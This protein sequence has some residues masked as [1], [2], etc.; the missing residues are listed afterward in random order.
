[1]LYGLTGSSGTGKTTLGKAVAESLGIEFRPTSITECAR[2]HG[3][4]AVGVLPLT[5]R[6]ALQNHLLEDHIEMLA[7]APRP[8]IVD[9]TPIDFIGY[10]MAEFDMHSHMRA[11]PEELVAADDY[12]Q[13]C[14]TATLRYYDHVFILGQLDFYEEAATRPADNRAYQTHS[15]LIMEGA[16]FKL[17][18]RVSYSAIYKNDFEA[19]ETFVHDTIVARLDEIE[20]ERRSAAHIN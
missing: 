9:R 15:Q 17:S 5:D 13:R 19:R 8:L 12:V 16:L 6:L 10:L 11:S 14:L 7:E 18:G 1:M 3:F 20:K 2:R 4:N